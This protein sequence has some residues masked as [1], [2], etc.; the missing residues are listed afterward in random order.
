MRARLIARSAPLPVYAL[1]G[2]NAT[3][4]LRLSD[5]GFAGFAAIEALSQRI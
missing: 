2:V 3:T 1:G 5:L 4:A